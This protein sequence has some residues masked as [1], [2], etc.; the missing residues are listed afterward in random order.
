MNIQ[1]TS[2]KQNSI[3]IHLLTG[4]LI[5]IIVVTIKD[6]NNYLT[7]KTDYIKLIFRRS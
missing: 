1:P 2:H 6:T 4:Q 3:F 5:A 7:D